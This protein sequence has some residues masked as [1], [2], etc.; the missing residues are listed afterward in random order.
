M[1]KLS[2]TACID[3][4]AEIVWEQL[5]RLEDIQRWGPPIRRAHC[6]GAVSRG[7]GAERM[8]ELV[9][10]LYLVENG[11]PYEGRHSDLPQAPVAC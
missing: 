1:I 11:R 4:S 10:G 5:A 2:A 8:C 7:V 6:P 9:G 3:A